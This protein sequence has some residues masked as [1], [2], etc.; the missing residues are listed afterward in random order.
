MNFRFKVYLKI[1]KSSVLY[2]KGRVIVYT[3]R[4][5]PKSCEEQN[6]SFIVYPQLF[7]NFSDILIMFFLFLVSKVNT[8]GF[9]VKG[10]IQL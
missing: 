5:M 10:S 9:V 4:F 2:E 3:N 8:R 7:C 6:G 1:T